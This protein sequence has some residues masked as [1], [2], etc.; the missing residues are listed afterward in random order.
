MNRLPINSNNDDEYYDLLVTRQ[1]RND[2]NY[3]TARSY[4]SLSIDSTVT[5][6]W[7]YGRPW[8]HGT[9]VGR[10]GQNH[11]NRSHVIRISERGQIV[12][13]NSKHIKATPITAE[14]Y[15]RDQI[16]ENTTD[17]LNE[18]LKNYE[19]LTQE[20]VSNKH[21]SLRREGTFINNKNDLYRPKGLNFLK[22]EPKFSLITSFCLV[23]TKASSGVMENVSL[24][25]CIT[26]VYS[27][28]TFSITPDE[29]LVEARQKL[30]IRENFGSILRKLRPFG[31]HR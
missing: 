12:T 4:D 22:I 15:L 20:N 8:T 21:G 3:V 26:K 7:E 19:K 14:Q 27:R 16:N 10:G 2:K 5:V 25:R 30:V 18:I 17:P 29:A 9:V 1:T 23:S 28:L 11:N 31:L 24:E 6:Q 13:R